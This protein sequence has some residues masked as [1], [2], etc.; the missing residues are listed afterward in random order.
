MSLTVLAIGYIS[1]AIGELAPKMFK[2]EDDAATFSFFCA[3][4]SLI[5]F[6]SALIKGS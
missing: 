6:I 1:L 3:V 2:K 4:L 5:F